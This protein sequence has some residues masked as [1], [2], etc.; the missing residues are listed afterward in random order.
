MEKYQ[1]QTTV[2]TV[3]GVVVKK[4]CGSCQHKCVAN[5]GQ[6]LC[7]LND[8]LPVEQSDVC[9]NW[10]LDAAFEKVRMSQG[11]IKRRAYLLY[12]EVVRRDE[13]EGIEL[14]VLEEEDRKPIEVIRQEFIEKYG[15]IY[16]N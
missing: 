10:Q 6:R 14:G 1:S 3:C 11:R 12:V 4:W 13:D 9:P 7:G 15:S 8:E 16:E 2:T 5:N